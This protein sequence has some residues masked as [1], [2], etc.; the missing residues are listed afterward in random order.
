MQ[1]LVA[2]HSAT[3]LRVRILVTELL[4]PAETIA[5]VKNSK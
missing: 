1:T 2:A 5:L 3:G 4:S